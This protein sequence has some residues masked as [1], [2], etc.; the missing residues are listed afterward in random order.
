MYWTNRKYR[1]AG[2]PACTII[3]DKKQITYNFAEIPYTAAGHILLL[4]YQ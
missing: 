1:S 4:I 2:I 3:A